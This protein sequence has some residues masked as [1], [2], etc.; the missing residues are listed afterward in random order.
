MTLTMQE[1]IPIGL[2]IATQDLMDAKRFQQN[3]ADNLVLRIR[4]RTL[5]PKLTPIKRELNSSTYQKKYVE[6][7]K[8]VIISNI[9]KIISIVTA[10]YT[11]L[12]LNL[13]DS[14][15]YNGKLIIQKVLNADSFEKIAEL[16][17]VF[18]SKITLPVYDLFIRHMKKSK[19]PMI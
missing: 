2:C 17:S 1:V 12:D 6:G 15:V 19:I 3:F 14:I 10:R 11:E 4:D 9:D 18:K 13:V 5:E 16:D 8:T 7:H